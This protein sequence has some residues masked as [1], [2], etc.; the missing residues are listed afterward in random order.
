MELYCD[1]SYSGNWVQYAKD[2]MD[3]VGIQPCGHSARD[4]GILLK[5]RASCISHQRGSSFLFSAR[6]RSNDKN[7]G[8][9]YVYHK[10]EI[11]PDQ[12]TQGID[13]TTITCKRPVEESCALVPDFTFKMQKDLERIYLVRG[14][15]RGKEAWHYVL[16]VDDAETERLFKE[17]VKDGTIDVADYGSVL[18]SGWGKDPPKKVTD[19]ISNVANGLETLKYESK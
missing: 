8:A 5:V 1:C 4:T 13:F 15:D 7:T 6:G 17:K 9:L 11:G 12:T 14:K 16:L 2:F 19:W 18:K 10:K 3:E